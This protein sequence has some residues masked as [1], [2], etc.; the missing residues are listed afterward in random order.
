MPWR[1]CKLTRILEPTLSGTSLVSLVVNISPS[2]DEA[3]ETLNSLLFGSRAKMINIDPYDTINK[4]E[5]LS[6]LNIIKKERFTVSTV[7][8][9]FLEIVF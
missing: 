7:V 1:D 3:G 9:L 4:R 8:F 2:S 6:K 5:Q